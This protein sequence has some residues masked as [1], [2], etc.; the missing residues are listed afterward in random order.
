VN[1]EVSEKSQ[2]SVGIKS[3]LTS[4]DTAAL[5]D[6]GSPDAVCTG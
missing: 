3:K 6:G 1:F 4:A 5:F 2:Q